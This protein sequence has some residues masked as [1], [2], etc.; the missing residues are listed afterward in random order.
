MVCI[1]GYV[2]QVAMAN[3]EFRAQ[4][5]DGYVVLHKTIRFWSK[6][7]EVLDG[8]RVVPGG[9]DEPMRDTGDLEIDGHRIVWKI[10]YYD[11]LGWFR[12]QPLDKDC[13]RV[14]TA[15]VGDGFSGSAREFWQQLEQQQKHKK[16]SIWQQSSMSMRQRLQRVMTSSVE[17]AGE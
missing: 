15:M 10:H 17:P 4:L 16:E 12:C 2:T 8:L 7:C 13:V 5:P 11:R 1:D 6:A 3:D 14:L 9:A